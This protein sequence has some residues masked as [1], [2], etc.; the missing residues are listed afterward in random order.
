MFI[1]KKLTRKNRFSKYFNLTWK[2]IVQT[3][4]VFLSLPTENLRFYA[5]NTASNNKSENFKVLNF[6]RKLSIFIEIFLYNSFIFSNDVR[7]FQVI[8][9]TFGNMSF[10]N[11]VPKLKNKQDLK[12]FF[13]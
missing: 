6:A 10:L 7:K 8:W 5:I 12:M 4:F 2:I 13:G 11:F 3:C 1:N 9:R